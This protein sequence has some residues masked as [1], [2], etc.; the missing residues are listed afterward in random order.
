MSK[1]Q[2]EGSETEQMRLESM[3]D[4][5]T[6]KLPQHASIGSLFGS[7][8]E[9]NQTSN[10]DNNNVNVN[11][12]VPEA[13]AVF[14]ARLVLLIVLMGAAV[15][16]SIT[17][18]MYV[19]DNENDAFDEHFEESAGKILEAI[20]NTL[21]NTFSSLDVLAASMVGYAD[22]TVQ[23]WP[24]VTVPF[25]GHSASKLLLLS[26]L[27]LLATLPV[28]SPENRLEWEEY[29][30][31]HGKDWIDKDMSLMETDP[32]Y[33]GPI[34]YDYE[35]YGVIFGELEDVPY[36]TTRNMLPNWQNYPVY[37]YEDEPPYNFDY[38]SVTFPESM[39]VT[40]EKGTVTITE[41]YLLPDPEEEEELVE[42]AAWIDWLSN[43]VTPE[44]DPSEPVSD[45]YF[46][47]FAVTDKVVVDPSEHSPVGV[48][49]GTFYWR[50]MIAGS[51][52]RG[53]D[54]VI[55][56]FTNSC[57][58]TF[59]YKIDGPEA[60][61]L[62]RGDLHDQQFDD[63]VISS[64]F[65]DLRHFNNIHDSG[66]TGPTL[67]DGFCP[68]TFHIYPSHE[69]KDTHVSKDPVIFAV[70][71]ALIFIFTSATF[72]VYD[73]CVKRRQR[74]LEDTA[75]LSAE[76]VSLLEQMVKERT[77]SL[78]RSMKHVNEANERIKKSAAAQLENYAAMSHEIRTPLNCIIGLSS[79]LM[80]SDLAASDRDSVAMI[81]SSGHL[82]S[83][84]IDDVLDYSKLESGNV[85]IYIR[86]V[87]FHDT[88][89]TVVRSIATKC[90]EN[91]L[92]LET[93]YD[94]SIPP[95]IT[96]DSRRL[97]Q[98]LFNLLGNSVKFSK[99]NG[100]I[101]LRVACC[102]SDKYEEP[103][104]SFSPEKVTISGPFLRISV[105]DYGKGIP[106]D[107]LGPIFRAFQQASSD[108]EA[109]YGGSGLGLSIT[110]K[111]V[112]RLG[113]NI[114]VASEEGKWTEFT[115]DLPFVDKM[116]D[117]ISAGLELAD[118]GVFVVEHD[119]IVARR[120]SDLFSAYNISPAKLTSLNEVG[121]A[122][123]PGDILVVNEE[124][125]KTGLHL[126]LVMNGRHVLVTYGPLFSV[127]ESDFHFRSILQT[128]PSVVMQQ[129]AEVIRR[130]QSF[131]KAA[132]QPMSANYGN[133]DFSSLRVLVAEDLVLNQKVLKRLLGK[134]GVAN[135]TMANNGQI[136]VEKE[137]E[138]VFDI[139]FMDMQ[140]STKKG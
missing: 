38:M 140:V 59:T 93:Y 106:Q 108:T 10:S 115:I 11:L 12:A 118:R 90:V 24:F 54:P 72:L 81:V 133:T 96:T 102:S 94:A 71:T 1:E 79:L 134:L 27:K 76:N 48:L 107:A 85:D 49:T 62:G 101:E 64:S 80:E 15:G 26:K 137:A 86:T 14:W 65:F 29:S 105:K 84:V 78:E 124:L 129:I 42:T 40:L 67:D 63:M 68:F 18:L 116:F 110:S 88:F 100:V 35:E 53:Y 21:D 50:D 92:S 20:G 127:T 13:K 23:N 114:Y 139:V 44:E 113:G 17:I 89:E 32:N 131:E 99:P 83:T 74:K 91:N 104:N 7:T 77:Q 46:P 3:D 30:L 97:Q 57:N 36:N 9:G 112:G 5:D 123:S 120:I 47:F 73:F 130:R 111:L 98:C 119:D 4:T 138:D 52:P 25:F 60:V 128:L 121:Q 39:E 87:D 69:M 51:L 126:P 109:L 82:L 103:I 19:K 55:A 16:V 125:C 37:A 22:A 28:V 56:V 75:I 43:F 8:T 95:K 136:A 58:P 31:L 2:P 117:R 41:A 61:F 66:Y 135:V 34:Y 132:A 6:R 122:I 70:G 45:I 33:F